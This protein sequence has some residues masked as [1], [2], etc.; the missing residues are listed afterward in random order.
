[1]ESEKNQNG[2][3]RYKNMVE[4]YLVQPESQLY[5]NAIRGFRN[6]CGREI[7]SAHD[8]SNAQYKIDEIFSSISITHIKDGLL[9][10][11]LVNALT[12]I[13]NID[14]NY[15]ADKLS[16]DIIA[17]PPDKNT[18]LWKYF[19]YILLW[20]SKPL[21]NSFSLIL[22]PLKDHAISWITG[23]EAEP[24]FAGFQLITILI[25][26]FPT[27]LEGVYSHVINMIVKSFKGQEHEI[28]DTAAAALIAALDHE[29][30]ALNN[31]IELL[32][33]SFDKQKHEQYPGVCR[34]LTE[35]LDHY[36]KAAYLIRFKSVPLELLSNKDPSIRTYGYPVLPL[37]WRTSPELFK[38]ETQFQL[39][40]LMHSSIKKKTPHRAEALVSLG[41]F[42]FTKGRISSDK[43]PLI[44]K[45]RKSVTEAFDCP[46]AAY[47][48]L[49]LS[50]SNNDYF[51]QDSSKI[52]HYLDSPLLTIGF[53]RYL[54]IVEDD[55]YV[56]TKDLLSHANLHLLS[57][58]CQS[59]IVQNMFDR[60]LTLDIDPSL[61][62]LPLIL[63]Y[64]YHMN[65][66]N[67]GVKLSASKVCIKYLSACYSIELAQRLIAFIP[68]ETDSNLRVFLLKNIPLEQA[69]DGLVFT[70]ESLLHDSQQ[71]IRILSF[72]RLV[73]LSKHPGAKRAIEALLKEKVR[74]LQ[75]SE[76]LNKEDIQ[77]FII[78]MSVA[79]KQDNQDF[80]INQRSNMP[81]I[82]FLINRILSSQFR[83]SSTSLKL[84][85]IL[86]PLLPTEVNIDLLSKHI[87]QSL[88]INST[89]NRLNSTL[90]LLF[91][92]L[93]FTQIRDHLLSKD[94]DLFTKLLQI[95]KLP[96]NAVDRTKLLHVFGILGASNSA[97]INGLLGNGDQI[98][99]NEEIKIN[100]ANHFISTAVSNDPL[101]ALTET[102]IGISLINILDILGNESL[103]ALHP[104]AIEALLMF[105]KTNRMLNNELEVYLIRR[106]N[107]LLQSK[108]TST[109]TVL[110][111]NMA[112]LITAIGPR[113]VPLVPY[114]IDLICDK[115]GTTDPVI[116]T[117]TCDWLVISIPEAFI[118][119]MPRIAQLFV[120]DFDLLPMK[121]IDTILSCFVSFGLL[122]GS[123]SHII[124]PPIL[125]WVCDNALETS[126]C[127]QALIR[128]KS[129]IMNGGS[130]KL[131]SYIF[132]AMIKVTR[133]NKELHNPCAD[134]V[135]I[136]AVNIGPS[137]VL[138][139]QRLAKTFEFS[140]NRN[141]EMYSSLI[142]IGAAIPGVV[143][144]ETQ[145]TSTR[146]KNTT[147]QQKA[148]HSS[149]PFVST[150]ELLTKITAPSSNH[151]ESAW[152]IWYNEVVST[153][154]RQSASRAISSCAQLAE[155]HLPVMDSIF[156]IAFAMLYFQHEKV[157]SDQI[158]E[159]MKIIFTSSS[160]PRYIML[161]FLAVLELIEV[162][163][164]PPPVPMM[165]AKQRAL[166]VNNLAQ[167]LRAAESLYDDGYDAV[168]DDL[169]SIN[170]ELGLPLA[171]Q[172]IL[173]STS[174]R[175]TSTTN[176]ELAERL[177]LWE[178]ALKQYNVTLKDDSKNEKIILGKLNCLNQLS[179]YQELKEFS[180]IDAKYKHYTAAALWGLFDS[181]EFVKVSKE[182]DKESANHL[183][184]IYA[185]YGLL[186]TREFGKAKELIEKIEEH[187]LDRIFPMISEDYE[188]TYPEYESIALIRHIAEVID[189]IKA[190]DISQTASTLEKQISQQ[191]IERITNRW[192]QRFDLLPNDYHVLFRNLQ[193]QNLVKSFKDIKPMWIRFF[194]VAVKSKATDI[195]LTTLN[196]FMQNNKDDEDLKMYYAKY[197]RL[198]GDKANA[199]AKMKEIA[200]DKKLSIQIQGNSMLKVGEWLKLDGKIKESVE[201]FRK[202]AEMLDNSVEA[203]TQ[204]SV[205]N[206][207][208]FEKTKNKS[209]IM[210]SITSS[211]AGLYIANDH[212][213]FTLRA[214]SILFRNGSPEM[215]SLFKSR[216]PTIP[217]Y[218]WLDV[219]P[220]IIARASSDDENLRQIITDIL[221]ATGTSFP[222][223]TLYS[224]SVPLKSDTT[225]RQKIASQIYDRLKI[226]YPETVGQFL[227]FTNEII[228]IAVSWW[229]LWF[230]VLDDASRAYLI[231][232]DVNEMLSLLLPAHEITE[233][234]PKTYYEIAFVAQ[235]GES[236]QRAKKML[237]DYKKTNDDIHL[238]QAWGI[239]I[240]I[241]NQLKPVIAEIDKI[242][243]KDASEYL[244]ETTNYDICLPGS[245]KYSEDIIKIDKIDQKLSVMK[246]KQRPRRMAIYGT[247][248]IRYTF[249]LKAHE[250]T[251]L[252]ERV[253]QLF[254]FINRLVNN[255]TIPMKQHLGITTYNVIPL[256]GQVGFIGWVTN[257]STVYELIKQRR[258]KNNVP[259]EIE[260]QTT[261]K[262]CPNFEQ[263]EGAD[264]MFAFKKGLSATKGDDLKAILLLNS[265]DSTHWIERRTA[266]TT[267]LSMTSMAGYILGLGD[268]HLSNI[269][270][271]NKTAKLV[272]IDFGDCFEVAQH[273]E[274]APEKV[275]FRLTRILT[276][277]LE[278]SRIEGTFR[279]CCENVMELIRN[280]G[281]QINGILEVFIYDPLAQWSENVSETNS[282][283]FVTDRIHSKLDGTDFEGEKLDVK[284][285][286][287]RLIHEATDMK[288]LCQM[289]R[290]WFPWW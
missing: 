277:A 175:G 102:A 81:Y 234:E 207:E 233:K 9:Y 288:N 262:A 14:K 141:F 119:H 75:V 227:T 279:S 84:L 36:P 225:V 235:F 188:R 64:L 285:Q 177:G 241:F 33:K 281:E 252:D 164:A 60:I 182:L 165:I 69:D 94:S 110:L 230:G 240:S 63:E 150:K 185:L 57:N 179:K 266:Y 50:I 180:K 280:N 259:V 53:K 204:W 71:E 139:K 92:S 3:Q 80:L 194:D 16:R 258:E 160:V 282:A 178:D 136:V 222:H 17:I 19:T 287:D 24:R 168:S 30:S 41:N 79:F 27:I 128:L 217:I 59:D 56:I 5:L 248:G 1:M 273:R 21:K 126:N 66:E 275:P 99:V 122:I 86:I 125:D 12:E 272:H 174:L 26:N 223:T 67:T 173:R 130:V 245:F 77:I 87:R 247:D 176:G 210:D 55:G 271:K 132:N 29:T 162:L 195:I 261:M 58:N 199:I 138:H 172:G 219:M 146:R 142:E 90:D 135:F 88:Q 129:I 78:A 149:A 181:E 76:V 231:K 170:Q 11:V 109:I 290:G 201:Y 25:K 46:E 45:C 157:G 112:T 61:L 15:L 38:L 202:A 190:S 6:F 159:I 226:L 91:S 158:T 97:F 192:E 215:Y 239:Y 44:Q 52:Y 117:R 83:L 100:S 244:S 151:S 283:Q 171:A 72:E 98:N 105:L 8:L 183:E 73:Q 208:M 197:L 220:Q 62:S 22:N 4:K 193:V 161:N 37:I 115:W 65:K 163:G 238:I 13:P 211:I 127:R 23:E 256:T 268:R 156:P 154:I 34:A 31:V 216:V 274:K 118:P 40:L 131:A 186:M 20:I 203:L 82:Q 242:N 236:L 196:H 269:M 148:V 95:A 155:R 123:V 111:S 43:I 221:L 39:Y 205:I 232:Q 144:A 249:L 184:R 228:R 284:E 255:S 113:F 251:R 218:V 289:W 276:N 167:A 260:Y 166:S 253:M 254:G 214:L 145:P 169:I 263:I 74:N 209:Y 198:S 49:A 32:M 120:K 237:M 10:V 114:V 103:A 143:I 147:S 286:V 213:S 28:Y 264:K 93:K 153:V 191:T 134:I 108:G 101:N 265:S 206:L 68:T 200:N 89:P 107:E 152:I 47:C 257:C 124:L 270:I 212:L 2:V 104:A 116:L 243:L 35:I 70:L 189:Y 246:S 137:F 224:L 54:D 250:D 48:L 187:K 267:S 18:I 7:I 106:I 85:A 278:V 140:Y 133:I 96:K 121:T 229:E 51:K 42:V